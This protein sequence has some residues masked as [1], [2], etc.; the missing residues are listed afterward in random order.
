MQ[1]TTQIKCKCS[2]FARVCRSCAACQRH[3][4]S[5]LAAVIGLS[6]NDVISLRHLLSIRCV[7]CVGWKLRLS[8]KSRRQQQQRVTKCCAGRKF[9]ISD[10]VDYRCSKFQF[11]PKF[12]QKGKF[13]VPNFVFLEE[14]FLTRKFSIRLKFRGGGQCLL[15]IMPLKPSDDFKTVN[16]TTNQAI[17]EKSQI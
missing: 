6:S 11:S 9:H 8:I 3:T 15:T 4:P 2:N 17:N 10:R 7:R 14:N 13:S 5:S 16:W 12:P 1:L